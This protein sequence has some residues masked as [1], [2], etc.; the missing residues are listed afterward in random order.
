M[1]F[2]T[3]DILLAMTQANLQTLTVTNSL[4]LNISA[5]MAA[6]SLSGSTSTSYTFS[7]PTEAPFLKQAQSFLTNKGYFTSISKITTLTNNIPTA[8]A[9][10][11]I[12]WA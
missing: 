11:N 2:P 4:G 7:D 10:L 6:A 3:A 8:S 9:I 12:N 5:S 1:A